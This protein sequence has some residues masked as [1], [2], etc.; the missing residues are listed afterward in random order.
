MI[1]EGACSC[2]CLETQ[3]PWE[4]K[5]HEGEERSA[6]RSDI[7]AYGGD[8]CIERIGMGEP[9]GEP[10]S[11]RAARRLSWWVVGMSDQSLVPGPNPHLG[12]TKFDWWLTHVPPPQR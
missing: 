9:A 3:T 4:E 2:A 8:V 7:G 1:W 10:L 12:S 5:H 6:S 11:G